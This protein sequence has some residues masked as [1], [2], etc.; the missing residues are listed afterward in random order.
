MISVMKGEKKVNVWDYILIIGI[1]TATM[2]E[3]RV[4]K[5]GI[6]EVL[7]SLWIVKTTIRFKDIFIVNIYILFW[8]IFI[9]CMAVGTFIANINNINSSTSMTS[10]FTYFFFFI[11]TFSLSQYARNI[12]YEKGM[13]ILKKIYFGG[14]Y[15]YGF[16]YIF[17]FFIGPTILGFDLWY[18]PRLS[19]LASNPHQFVF[20]VAPLLLLGI[21]LFKEGNLNSLYQKSL[22]A[23]G[24]LLFLW[25]GIET[26]SSTFIGSIA[27]ILI[28]NLFFINPFKLQ[29]KSLILSRLLIA[30][31]LL[32]LVLLL[33]NPISQFIYSFIESDEN[34]LGR[35]TLWLLGIEKVL[36]SPIFGLGFGTYIETGGNSFFQE[37]HNVYIDIAT[38]GGLIS[39]TVFLGAIFYSLFKLR[40]N[41]YAV[42]FILFFISYGMAGYTVRRVTMWFFI[43]MLFYLGDKYSNRYKKPA[44]ETNIKSVENRRSNV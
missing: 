24:T 21:Y 14:L 36:I 44:N 25:M 1:L 33:A 27:I 31:S 6:S 9:F 2:T 38:R 22:I 19:I 43:I 29:K 7:L 5:I 28:V 4:G 15:L 26:G 12:S 35:I 42:N 20:I 16:L 23:I 17:A 8:I 10:I 34:G 40:S 41:L 30:V 3:L 39:L 13:E 37:A 11:F 18:G 32:C